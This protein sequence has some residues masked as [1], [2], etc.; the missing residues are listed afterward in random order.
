M[1]Y[2]IQPSEIDGC[3]LHDFVHDI[4]PGLLQK[5]V[6][7]LE[8]DNV[9]DARTILKDVD[10]RLK[11]FLMEESFSEWIMPTCGHRDACDCFAERWRISLFPRS[12][13][14]VTIMSASVMVME[15]LVDEKIR[16]YTPESSTNVIHYL[17]YCA[18]FNPAKEEQYLRFYLCLKEIT[19]FEVFKSLLLEENPEGLNSL[20]ISAS[21]GLFCFFED[22]FNTKGIY[23]M[24]QVGHSG[25]TY[26]F[27]DVTD[28]EHSEGK[29]RN[30]SPLYIFMTYGAEDLLQEK[31]QISSVLQR[32][33]LGMKKDTIHSDRSWF[34]FS[35]RSPCTLSLNF[36]FLILAGRTRLLFPTATKP[37]AGWKRT[38][39]Q[40]FLTGLR[41]VLRYP[42]V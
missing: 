24:N 14:S 13:L 20:E 3:Q 15:M 5:W 10:E 41:P 2:R 27:Y 7:A 23:L 1:H 9:E 22:I 34:W 31:T 35:V 40:M 17:L 11:S 6:K 16:F 32:C 38:G 21:L 28:Y 42:S 36:F 19:D 29:R 33:K 25:I 12:T 30:Y 18:F 26:N 39:Q 4:R 37:S 8:G